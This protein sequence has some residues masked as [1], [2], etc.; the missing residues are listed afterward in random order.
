METNW[1]MFCDI[2]YFDLWA[3]RDT[4]DKSFNSPRLFHFVEQEDAKAFL[5]LVKKSR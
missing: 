1:E 2:G 4:S 3:V 5:A